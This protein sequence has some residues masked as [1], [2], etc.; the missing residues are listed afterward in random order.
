M[1]LAALAVTFAVGLLAGLLSGLVGIGGGVLMVPFLPFF[2]A[3]APPRAGGF[4]RKRFDP[5]FRRCP[6][7][8]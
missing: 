1:G 7:A 8:S 2:Y 5:T 4:L 6:T 3:Q